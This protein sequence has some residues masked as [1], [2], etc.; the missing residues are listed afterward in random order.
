MR[1]N[2]WAGAAETLR[3]TL[4][5]APNYVPALCALGECMLNLKQVGRA[6]S[7]FRKADTISP[8]YLPAATGL[9]RVSLYREDY[10]AAE[11]MLRSAIKEKKGSTEQQT[12]ALFWLGKSM[13]AQGKKDAAAGILRSVLERDPGFV[14]AQLALDDLN[15][16]SQATDDLTTELVSKKYVN[17]RD[18]ARLISRFSADDTHFRNLNVSMPR[19]IRQDDEAFDA[20]AFVIT[21]GYLPVL[22]DQTFKPDFVI[23]RGAMAALL[24]NILAKRLNEPALVTKYFDMP[25]PYRD[26]ENVPL[27]INPLIVVTGYGLM[28]GWPDGTFRPRE[29]VSGEEAFDIIRRLFEIEPKQMEATQ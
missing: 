9:A 4:Q 17:R 10:A 2:D 7:L 1:I 26:V 19:D 12:E 24:Q 15:N 22:P 16:G 8:D 23:D 21:K 29:P 28:S 14:K 5:S 18:I 6:D 11:T 20:I 13:A 3:Q 25:A 27:L